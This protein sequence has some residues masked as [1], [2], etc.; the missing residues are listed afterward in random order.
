MAGEGVKRLIDR[1][2]EHVGDAE[3]LSVVERRPDAQNLFLVA[4]PAAVGAGKVDVGEKLHLDMLPACAR[5]A[6][7]A[8]GAG[9][10]GE[11]AGLESGDDGFRRGAEKFA[12]RRECAYIA[13]GIAARGA[14][15]GALVDEFNAGRQV[16]RKPGG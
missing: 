7:A 4:L 11:V 3:R 2:V 8:A 14:P 12:D 5:T 13:R 10:E 9:I 1:E 16:A 15:E 6:G